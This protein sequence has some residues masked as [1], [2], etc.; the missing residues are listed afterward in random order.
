[1]LNKLS[2]LTQQSFQ[3]NLVSTFWPLTQALVQIVS[4][5]IIDEIKFDQNF[6]IIWWQT[7]RLESLARFKAHK[8]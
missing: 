5:K 6:S 8:K 1:M 2:R 7:L 3:L 4:A